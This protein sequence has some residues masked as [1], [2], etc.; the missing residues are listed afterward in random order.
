VEPDA[1]KVIAVASRQ[2]TSIIVPIKPNVVRQSRS[3]MIIDDSV[4]SSRSKT[5]ELFDDLLEVRSFKHF[6]FTYVRMHFVLKC[7]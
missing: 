1:N 3:P 6:C 4:L 5:D 7:E 2:A